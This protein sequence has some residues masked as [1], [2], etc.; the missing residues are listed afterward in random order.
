MKSAWTAA[1]AV[2]LVLV[3]TPASAQGLVDAAK[4]A[5]ESR[6]TSSGTEI[7][8]DE[9]DVN[10]ALAAREVLGYR[11][12]EQRWN[13]YL[14][15]DNRVMDAMEKDLALY[16]RLEAL[17]ASNARM[18]ERFFLREAT[19]LKALEASSMD[20]HEY[21]YTSVAIGV[22]MAVIAND[23]GPEALQQLPDATKTNIAFVRAHEGEIKQLLARGER[24]RDR[25]AQADGI[26]R[27]GAGFLG[28]GSVAATLKGSGA[29]P[30]TFA[31]R[32]DEVNWQRYLAADKLVVAVIEKNP[33][34]FGRLKREDLADG[35]DLAGAL[36][37]VFAAEPEIV[38]ALQSVGSN[39]REY[40]RTQVA[41]AVAAVFTFA[42]PP[43]ELV[44]NANPVVK[45]NM[46]FVR[47]HERE[48]Q[49]QIARGQ[50]LVA[51]MQ[52]R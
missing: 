26:D 11:I 17:R 22:S 14:A 6:K 37:N 48:V 38:K 40:A 25:A 19:L 15:A 39:P 23:P 20:A 32:L 49:E 42:N 35:D 28:G 27:T 16:T 51:R 13:A 9:R 33:T 46:A 30:R 5:D 36:E 12:N 10:P 2:A 43:P 1:A 3:C 34:L 50:A 45:A 7:R 29:I 31:Y 44:A 18:I 47:A 52:G 8:F 4:R 24:L 41:L 21:A